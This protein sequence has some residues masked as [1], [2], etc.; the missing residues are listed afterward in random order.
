MIDGVGFGDS[1]PLASGLAFG[2]IHAFDIISLWLGVPFT[3]HEQFMHCFSR[4][5]VLSQPCYPDHTLLFF[6]HN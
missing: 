4:V 6:D 3:L 1:E 5:L 2:N